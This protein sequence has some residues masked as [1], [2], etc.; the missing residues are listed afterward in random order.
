[1]S[2]GPIVWSIV[3]VLVALVVLGLLLMGTLRAV[4]RTTTVL[5][6][7][8]DL[9]AD[10][11]GMLRARVAAIQVRLARRRSDRASTPTGEPEPSD[12]LHG[13]DDPDITAPVQSAVTVPLSE[14]APHRGE[15]SDGRSA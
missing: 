8:T 7:F 4:G 15:R 6:A 1:V 12:R 11:T 13:T 2:I 10:R 5:G 3:V 14:G 9:L